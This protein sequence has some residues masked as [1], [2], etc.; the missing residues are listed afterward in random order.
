MSWSPGLH[1][2][3]TRC[4]C[5][6]FHVPFKGTPS[7]VIDLLAGRVDMTFINGRLIEAA[8]IKGE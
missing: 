6:R 7:V 1:R 3:A 5:R 4:C 8:G 2:T